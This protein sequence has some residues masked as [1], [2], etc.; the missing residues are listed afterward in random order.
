MLFSDLSLTEL[1]KNFVRPFRRGTTFFAGTQLI[2]PSEL[3][4]VRIIET[5]VP[6]SEARQR[7]N[8]ESLARI[9]EINRTSNIVFL[10]AGEGYEPE[11]LE[12]AGADVTHTYLAKGPGS[13]GSIWGFSRTVVAWSLGIVATVIAAGLAKWL[14]WA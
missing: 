10:S 5:S 12:Q 11:D 14:G 4:A 1:K 6:E 9:D 2:N 13:L 3:R 7:I 8:R